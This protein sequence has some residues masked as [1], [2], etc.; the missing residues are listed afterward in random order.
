MSSGMDCAEPTPRVNYDIMQRYVGRKVRLVFKVE[1][2][3]GDKVKGT[4]CDG[5]TVYI[6]PKQG[7]NYEAAYMEVEGIVENGSTVQEES[8]CSFGDNFG[9]FPTSS[10]LGEARALCYR[11]ECTRSNHH[12]FEDMKNYDQLCKLSNGPVQELFL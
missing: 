5:Q 11:Y 1:E 3:A 4:T 6:R 9:K 8:Y 2:W 10:S 7:S 12:T